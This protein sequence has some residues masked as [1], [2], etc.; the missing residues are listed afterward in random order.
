MST[1]AMMVFYYLL[2]FAAI[3]AYFAWC[4]SKAL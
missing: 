2:F 3:F 1:E 4:A